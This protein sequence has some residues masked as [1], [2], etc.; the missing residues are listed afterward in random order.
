[1]FALT[2]IL[3]LTCNQGAAEDL[4]FMAFKKTQKKIYHLSDKQR[5]K[6]LNLAWTHKKN[7]KKVHKYIF[8]KKISTKV[9]NKIKKKIKKGFLNI[10]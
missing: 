5:Q 1:M 7:T 8:T 10:A 6:K 4:I 3:I 2:W 9:A